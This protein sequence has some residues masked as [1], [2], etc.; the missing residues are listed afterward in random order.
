[1]EKRN[2]IEMEAVLAIKELADAVLFM[3]DPCQDVASQVSLLREV[4]SGFDAP[5]FVAVNKE[6]ETPKERMEQVLEEVSGYPVFS[7][8]ANRSADC[9]RVFQSIFKSLKYAEGKN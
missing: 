8:S 5:V 9:V 6:D 2:K 3:V 1:M 7:I 4:S